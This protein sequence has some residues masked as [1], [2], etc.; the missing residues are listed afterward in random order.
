M[1]TWL[2]LLGLA[3]LGS[4]IALLRWAH[5][6][7]LQATRVRQETEGLKTLYRQHRGGVEGCLS[8]L[9]RG[10]GIHKK[11]YIGQAQGHLQS[12]PTCVGLLVGRQG[13]EHKSDAR[14]WD[15]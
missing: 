13:N 2:R 10:H 7:L 14:A 11:R 5:H 6:H 4:G 15:W 9:V 12:L 8:A 3:M 1:P